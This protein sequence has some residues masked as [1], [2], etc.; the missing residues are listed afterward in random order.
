MSPTVPAV[1]LD[2]VATATGLKT[3]VRIGKYETIELLLSFS[4][5]NINTSSH[6][7][8]PLLVQLRISYILLTSALPLVVSCYQRRQ[9]SR[10][11]LRIC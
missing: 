1:G 8:F 7:S 4:Y 9:R 6:L 5:V 2:L 11:R 10:H 3:V